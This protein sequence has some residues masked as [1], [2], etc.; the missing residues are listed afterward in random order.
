MESVSLVVGFCLRRRA[1]AIRSVRKEFGEGQPAFKDKGA[2]DP[3]TAADL[4][5]ERIIVGQ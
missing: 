5:S 4:E 2:Y 3:Q 1:A